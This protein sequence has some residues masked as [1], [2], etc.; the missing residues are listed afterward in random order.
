MPWKKT[1]ETPNLGGIDETDDIRPGLG[2]RGLEHLERF[3][4]QG[5]V[6]V[7]VENTADF[8]LQ[9]GLTHGVSGNETRG[10][11]VG[12]LLRSRIVDDKSPITYGVL[13]SLA[14]YSGAGASFGVGNMAGGRGRRFGDEESGRPTGRGR[15]DEADVPQGRP[16]LDPR[17][18]APARP[19]VKPWQAA[20]IQDEQLRNPLYVIPPAQRPRVALRFSD[21]KDLLVSGL[22]EG[23]G[24]IAQRPIVV[25]VPVGQGHVVLFSV[26]PIWRGATVGS[27]F[28]VFNTLLNFDHLHAGRVL[29]ER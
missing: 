18:E 10:R 21:Q 16:A 3:V 29:D 4:A 9:Y 27:Y 13:D 17:F 11:V 22:L 23:G 5:G 14:V 12:S 20:P 19:E 7:A 26:N 1:A 8:A 28:L 24:D 2:W 6:L 25:D 15:A